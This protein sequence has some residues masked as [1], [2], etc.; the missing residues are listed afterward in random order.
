MNSQLATNLG[1]WAVERG[2]WFNDTERI[3]NISE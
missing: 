3:S 1:M 2:A